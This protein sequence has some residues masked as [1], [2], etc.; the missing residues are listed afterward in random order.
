MARSLGE[1]AAEFGCEL[2]GDPAVEVAGVATLSN[3][4]PGQ[5]SFFANKNY[6]EALHTT[7]AA[8]VILSAGDADDCP[9]ACQYIPP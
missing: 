8:A 5:V 6:R 4:G 9:V 3:A 2:V 1:L 7:G